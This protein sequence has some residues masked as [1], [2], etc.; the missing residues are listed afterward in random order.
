ML[1]E[2]MNEGCPNLTSAALGPEI[3]SALTAFLDG[4]DLGIPQLGSGLI[5][6]GCELRF[7]IW[8]KALGWLC[9]EF[10]PNVD[11]FWVGIMPWE[12]C[13]ASLKSESAIV[14][15]RWRRSSV[16]SCLFTTDLHAS[17]S[18]L[19]QHVNIPQACFSTRGGT[20]YPV[21]SMIGAPLKKSSSAKRSSSFQCIGVDFRDLDSGRPPT[22][23]LRCELP[24]E[25]LRWFDG[26]PARESPGLD[27]ADGFE[28]V[29]GRFR[30]E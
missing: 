1:L 27:M 15:L 19:D 11:E 12:S 13:C 6:L 21:R 3:G 4:D 7:H 25:R 9:R 17:S 5:L 28:D 14:L 8:P 10:W 22:A 30:A 20:A 23:A 18:S 24:N 2:P 26:V 16:S 29:K